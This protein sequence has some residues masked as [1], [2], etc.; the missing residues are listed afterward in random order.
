MTTVPSDPMETRAIHLA[1]GTLLFL[2]GAG[3]ASVGS[4]DHQGIEG[5]PEPRLPV[6]RVVPTDA[7][8][9]PAEGGPAHGFVMFGSAVAMDG[10]LLA[11][12]TTPDAGSH[13]DWVYLFQTV[14]DGGWNQI[15]KFPSSDDGEAGGFGFAIDV[16]A[17][18]RTLAIG[19]P[20]Y[21]RP[22]VGNADDKDGVVYIFEE[23]AD[24]GWE[25]TATLFG[26]DDRS[27][28]LGAEFGRSIAIEGHTVA[29]AA[30]FEDLPGRREAGAVY[31]FEKSQD[32]W[33][34]DERITSNEPRDGSTFG[35]GRNGI[36]LGDKLLAVGAPDAWDPE[37]RTTSGAAY[38]FER[39][40]GSWNQT[41]RLGS[42]DSRVG[43]D[44]GAESFG[45]SLA[46][47]GRT[48]V[49]GDVGW[50]SQLSQMSVTSPN[51][52]RAYVFERGSDTWTQT[53]TL[54]PPDNTDGDWFGKFL[55]IDGDTVVVGAHHK[56]DPARA[57]LA[58]A[59]GRTTDGW[60]E[61][62][63][64]IS[65]E[66][67]YAD[68]F[69]WGLAVEGDKIAVGAPFDDNRRDAGLPVGDLHDRPCVPSEILLRCDDG[70]AAGSVFL[71]EDRRLHGPL[72]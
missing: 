59:F 32:G 15:A 67:S 29:V 70:E 48:L 45:F 25:R 63:V 40:E 42:P 6:E 72:E 31:T 10:D 23:L 16:D 9:T 26:R 7:N 56:P 30:P 41:A 53:A 43:E 46:L 20:G 11:V 64:L 2:A 49:V 54:A 71:F 51:A 12:G 39:S 61:K 18:T 44:A 65:N 28:Y 13:M 14:P 22:G 17:E 36:D 27:D 50:D 47:D 37:E 62:A 34:L 38:I 60:D 33:T 21:D 8:E 24:G 69:G 68:Y 1:L 55:D 19:N 52:G 4:L 58:Y 35:G 66:T 3:L 5:L 57:G